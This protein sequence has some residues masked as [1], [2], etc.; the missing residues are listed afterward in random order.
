MSHFLS[1]GVPPQPTAIIC[2]DDSMTRR[3]VREVVERCGF[4]VLAGVDN[5]MEALHLVLDHQP[6]VL[7]LDLVLPGISGEEIIS[8]I[9]DSTDTKVIVHSAYDPRKAVKSGARLFASKGNV[10]TLE[11]MLHKVLGARISA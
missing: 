5:A 9:Q 4:E 8:A 10:K 3:L 2:D 6:D 1:N 7:V 11:K